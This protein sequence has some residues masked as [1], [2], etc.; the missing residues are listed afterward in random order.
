MSQQPDSPFQSETQN[1]IF[2]F[3]FVLV[4]EYSQ[5]MTPPEAVEKACDWLVSL[6]TD[7]REKAQEHN[8]DVLA[9]QKLF[10]QS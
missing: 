6:A 1:A 7:I 4:N 9:K 2:N 3:L 5:T 10:E 8:A